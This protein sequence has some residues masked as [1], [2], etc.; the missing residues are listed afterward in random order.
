MALRYRQAIFQRDIREATAV[1][2]Q[3]EG[4][5]GAKSSWGT[6]RVT[7]KCSRIQE[8]YWNLQ[9]S[10]RP[11]QY[12]HFPLLGLSGRQKRRHQ[13]DQ[14]TVFQSSI[15]TNWVCFRP[16]PTWID[17][18]STTEK[19]RFRIAPIALVPSF[20]RLLGSKFCHRRLCSVE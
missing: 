15:P 19:P 5:G 14:A 20:L 1:D 8:S 11:L 13:P 7:S 17:T 3:E 18:S 4:R 2:V 10:C 16:A 12:Y 6:E 9:L